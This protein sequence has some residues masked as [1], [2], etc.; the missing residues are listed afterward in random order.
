M[1]TKRIRNCFLM[2]AFITFLLILIIPLTKQAIAASPFM[3]T[4]MNPQAEIKEIKEVP[5]SAR[6][7]SLDGKKIGLINNTKL[8]ATMLQPEIEKTIRVLFPNVQLKSW[9][10]SHVPFEDKSKALKE[11][12]QASDGVI[13]FL[14]D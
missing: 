1:E 9:I 10:I 7:R 5:P 2:V 14:G 11:V 4:V 6:I 12:A 3:L 13:L 8:G